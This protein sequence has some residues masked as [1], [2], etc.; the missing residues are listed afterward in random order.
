MDE[1]AAERGGDL[2]TAV[3]RLVGEL[4]D[5]RRLRAT[6]D[7]ARREAEARMHAAEAHAVR[8]AAEVASERARIGELERDRDEVI[9]RAEE[10]LTAVRVR[11][12]QRRAAELEAARRHWGELLADERRRVEAVDVERAALAQRV[13]DAWLAA[14]V[15]RRA[16]P[17]R[18]RSTAPTTPEAAEEE[19]LEALEGHETD[20]ALAADSPRLAEEIEQLRQRLRS[21]IHRAPDIPT[22]EDGVEDLRQARIA[23]DA[24]G[25]GRRRHR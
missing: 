23:R 24:E 8:S 16:R 20:P 7:A 15:L 14:A 5:E 11:A 19:M 18:P 10:L 13:Q 22:V 6:A 9:R 3:A 25:E 17:L 12:D 21:R 4:A 2:A 1:I